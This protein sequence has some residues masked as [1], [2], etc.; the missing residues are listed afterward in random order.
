MM[1]GW[2][3]GL[4]A[5]VGWWTGGAAGA[6]E[7]AFKFLNGVVPFLRYAKP[8]ILPERNRVPVLRCH[9]LPIG[10]RLLPFGR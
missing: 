9:A 6:A 8:T 10:G 3:E 2:R 5:A 1:L 7:S 4:Q